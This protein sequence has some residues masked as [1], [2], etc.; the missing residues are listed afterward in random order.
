MTGHKVTTGTRPARGLARGVPAPFDAPR[1]GPRIDSL[2]QRARII[3]A[4]RAELD[5]RGFVEVQ[6]PVLVPGSCPDRAIA[7]F[8]VPGAGYLVCVVYRLY[9][10]LRPATAMAPGIFQ[11]MP[12]PAGAMLAGSSVLLF[13]ERLPWLAVCLVLAS[14]LLMISSLRYRH[15]AQRLWPALP[16]MGKLLVCILFL[17]FVD[18]ALSHKNY[19]L[20]FSL[21]CFAL[22]LVYAVY[23]LDPDTYLPGRRRRAA[24]VAAAA[25]ADTGA[26][27]S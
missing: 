6:T 21:F 9:R 19:S 7:S 2:R 4:L 27:Q 18:V 22:G 24:Q 16:R 17:I 12:S 26:P 25:G 5:G 3:R 20:F 11:G 13:G 14:S 10:F 8:E 1:I 15:F 23:G